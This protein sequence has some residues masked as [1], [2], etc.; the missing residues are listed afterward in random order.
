MDTTRINTNISE[1]FLAEKIRS[2]K[3]EIESFAPKF[4]ELLKE[5]DKDALKEVA[6]DFEEL[7]VNLILK[8]MRSSIPKSSFAQS[9]Y[10]KEMFEGML[11]ESYAKE[12]ADSGGF[13]IADMIMNSFEPYLKDDKEELGR[14]F[15]FKG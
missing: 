2:D 12:I 7:F 9:S 6:A 8:T 13:G 5:G 14:R 4:Q 3:K 11:D 10:Q 15:D 1:G